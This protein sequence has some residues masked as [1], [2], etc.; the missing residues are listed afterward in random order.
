M[1]IEALSAPDQILLMKLISLGR[2][3]KLQLL[4]SGLQNRTI[5]KFIKY[6]MLE[7]EYDNMTNLYYFK[8]KEDV[9]KRITRT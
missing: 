4:S 8:V 2:K 9:K 5:E 1:I 7:K 3:T 6:D